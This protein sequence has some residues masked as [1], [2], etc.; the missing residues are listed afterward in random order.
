MNSLV[1]ILGLIAMGAVILA[2][3][4]LRKN[5]SLHDERAHHSPQT[6]ADRQAIRTQSEMNARV[7]GSGGMM[8]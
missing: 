5:I 4:E 6:E 8:F 2:L 3:Y 1:L 7:H